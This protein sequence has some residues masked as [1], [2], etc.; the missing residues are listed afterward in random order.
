MDIHMNNKKHIE[1]L[2]EEIEYLKNIRK[3]KNLT[4]KKELWISDRIMQL[5][6]CHSQ[7]ES[8]FK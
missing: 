4:L 3:T 6:K 2:N 8:F 1:I 5:I 7:I